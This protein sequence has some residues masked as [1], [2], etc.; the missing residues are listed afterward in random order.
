MLLK[1]IH[2]IYFYMYLFALLQ[3]F[4]THLHTNEKRQNKKG[5]R[6]QEFRVVAN[7]S[8][9]RVYAISRR[10][11]FQLGSSIGPINFSFCFL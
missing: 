6:V 1:F 9:C 2:Y 3:H 7:I 10:G 11:I 5:T 8:R 4:T